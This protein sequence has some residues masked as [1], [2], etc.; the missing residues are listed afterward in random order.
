MRV[1]GRVRISRLSDESTSIERQREIVESWAQQNDHTII[2]WAVDTDVSGSVSPFDTAGLGPWLREPKLSGWDILCA[3]KL[4]RLARRAVPLHRLFG[5]CQD[6]SKTLVCVSDSIDL[7]TW[8]GRLVASVIAGV[9]EGE[10]EA[11]QE[12]TAASHAKLRQLGRWPGGRPA[13]GYRAQQREDAAGWE[14]VPDE[15]SSGV[16]TSIV[17][18]VLAGQSIESIAR[19][20]TDAG[21]PSPADYVRQRSG[22]RLYP[23]DFIGPLPDGASR[24]GAWRAQSIF[25]LLRSN[26]LLGHVTHDGM[27]VRDLQG[28]PVL[29]GE[30]LISREKFDQLQATLDARSVVKSRTT[31]ASP[32]LGVVVCKQCDKPLNFRR[33][34][35]GGK[36]YAYYYCPDKHGHQLPADD[37]AQDLAEK[38]LGELAHEKVLQRQYVPPESHQSEL[39]EAVR[40]V[41]EITPLLGTVTSETLKTR[42]LSQLS[43]LDAKITQLE[44]LP[45]REAR[46]DYV[47]TGE[48]YG[49]AWE[50][51]G[52]EGRRQLLLRSGI[53]L[54]VILTNKS[55]KAG[56]GG[57]WYSEFRVPDD[58]VARMS[59]T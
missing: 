13:Y 6:H 56:S 54:A 49:D 55:R 36:E 40:A 44:T 43:A 42:L 30:P 25:R 35:V 22:A 11:I 10:L 2:G 47:E 16:L 14:L 38:F 23:R 52:T 46:W 15:H 57:S 21:E 29:K 59:N 48:T 45:V 41:D 53:T 5:L 26:T 18:Q 50:A 20:L 24:Q 12:R 27:T 39:D 8:V 3:W 9:A 37:L 17:D 7:S 1:L 58:V 4:D 33:Q 34:T 32:L 51:A 19:R 31:K 28:N